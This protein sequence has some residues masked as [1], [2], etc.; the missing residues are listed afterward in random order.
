MVLRAVTLQL[1]LMPRDPEHKEKDILK[2]LSPSAKP[3]KLTSRRIGIHTSTAGGVANAAERAY[4]LGCNA[5]QI[6]SSS[7]RQWKPYE[8]APQQRREMD[9]ASD[10]C[11][12]P[13]ERGGRESGVSR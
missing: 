4:R 12:L 2:L 9:A 11:K 13:G 10:P 6:F 3:P 7:P 1:T 8:L 5:F